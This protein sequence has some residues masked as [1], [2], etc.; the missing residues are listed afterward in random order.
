MAGILRNLGFLKYLY[1][2]IHSKQFS[3]QPSQQGLF[4]WD[5]QNKG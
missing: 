1:I 2:L 5:E 3:M 4:L